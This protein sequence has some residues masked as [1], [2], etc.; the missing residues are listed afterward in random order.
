MPMAIA[1]EPTPDNA[2]VKAVKYGGIVLCSAWTTSTMPTLNQGSVAATATPLQFNGTVNGSTT[3]SLIPFYKKFSGAYTVYFMASGSTPTATPTRTPSPGGPTP[4]P[5][6][7]PLPGAGPIH[8]YQFEGNANDSGSSIANGV[9]VNGPTFVA[10]RAGQALNLDGSNDHVSLPAGVVSGLG[11]FTISTWVKLDVSGAWRRICD[12]G[13]STTAN[14]F[15]T[16]QSS[17]NAPRFAIT[18][19]GSGGEQRINGSAALP[20]G[21]WKHLAVTLAG[22]TGR[23]Y[24]DGV[25]V[26]QNTSMTLRPSSLGSTSNNWLGR[27]QYAD[28]YLDGQLDEFRI[29]SRALSASEIL[30]LFQNP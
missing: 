23:L 5:T 14:M 4:T 22:N 13:S 25:Q 27:S 17:S 20:T 26:G 7:T 19:S 6:A 29:Y 18:T 28:P 15:L 24:V 1:F 9:L 8:R 30:A 2:S 12:F 11:D 16:P 21:V 10:G 3:V